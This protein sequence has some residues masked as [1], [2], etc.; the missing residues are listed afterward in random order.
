MPHTK[1][2]TAFIASIE[3]SLLDE[4]FVK[5]TLTNYKGNEP[6]LKNVYVKKVIIKE[7]DNLSFTCRFKTRDIV[8][9]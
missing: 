5:L 4:T 1:Q 8:K 3:Q 7:Q 6:A 9:N 2:R